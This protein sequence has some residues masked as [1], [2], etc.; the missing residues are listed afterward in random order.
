MGL[1]AL[2]LRFSRQYLAQKSTASS[3]DALGSF[4]NLSLITA[5]IIGHDFEKI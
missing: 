4:E 5:T 3:S 1:Y 2:I